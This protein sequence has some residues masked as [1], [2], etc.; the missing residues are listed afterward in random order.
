MN[1]RI[2]KRARAVWDVVG[3]DGVLTALVVI[4]CAN[5]PLLAGPG[6]ES[7]LVLGVVVPPAIAGRAAA[8]ASMRGDAYA[9]RIADACLRAATLAVV[10]SA[11][12][13][14][15]SLVGDACAPFAGLVYM[16]LGP[17]A[18]FVFAALVGVV[19]QRLART[20]GRAIT[21]AVTIPLSF[22]VLGGYELYA[23]PGVFLYSPFAGHLPGVLYDRTLGLPPPYLTYRLASALAMIGLGALTT[24]RGPAWAEPRR[25]AIGWLG[26]ALA[27]ACSF[28][29][30]SLGHRASVAHIRET[31]GARVDTERCVLYVPREMHIAER[32]R[33]ARDCDFHVASIERWLGVR[34]SGRAEV[35]FYRSAE[36]KRRLMGAADTDVA[37]PWRGEAHLVSE[38]WPHPVL[39]HELAHVVAAEVGSGP[40]RIAGSG[41]GFVPSPGLIEGLAVAASG[42]SR[43]GLGP[44]AWSHAMLELEILPS[45]QTLLGLGF[46]GEAPSTAYVASGSFLAFVRRTEGRRAIRDAYRRGGFDASR[47]AALERAWH[48][49]LRATPLPDGALEMARVRFERKGLFSAICPNLIAG[50]RGELGLARQSGDEREVSRVC[51]AILALDAN[52]A[53]ARVARIG[54]LAREGRIREAREARDALARND[55]VPTPVIAAADLALADAALERGDLGTARAAYDALL[56]TPLSEDTLR[57]VE[58]KRVAI[59]ASV[60]ERDAI[61]EIVIGRRGRAASGALAVHLGHRLDAMRGDGL[62]AYLVGRQLVNDSRFAHAVPLLKDA[63]RRGLP[64]PRLVRENARLLALALEGSAAC[65]EAATR[66]AA[67]QR[68]PWLRIDALLARERA[69]A[70]AAR[71][72]AH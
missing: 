48:V 61:L 38:P 66:Y 12:L 59:D 51:R 68:D 29:G 28:S 37:K 14:V 22:I 64:T 21:L 13:V 46:L 39:R 44:D 20:R 1:P 36:E 5:V 31:L 25:F 52:D 62:G 7:A 10:A 49:S 9:A 8:R 57:V 34:R 11:L 55:R 47:L 30:P 6:I 41:G 24:M 27:A 26:L 69:D 32:R 23:T 40:F 67:M 43:D 2:A 63:E 53:G 65:E 42:E 72:R 17:L 33:H 71:R 3:I 70:C 50:L 16:A 19:A 60:A 58:V 15:R 56:R 54:S 45:M 4:V 18:G 35:Y